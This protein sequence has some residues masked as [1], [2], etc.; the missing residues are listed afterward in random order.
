MDGQTC[1]ASSDV[2]LSRRKAKSKAPLPPPESKVTDC[3]SF[4]DLELANCTMD[5]KENVIDRDIQLSVLLPGEV[6]KTTNV[7]GS[8]PMMDL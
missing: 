2:A 1:S 6:I 8:K 3:S 4:D 5:Q 7:N